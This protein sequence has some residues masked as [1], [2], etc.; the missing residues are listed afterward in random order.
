MKDRVGES[1]LKVILTVGLC[2]LICNMVP[3]G[4]PLTLLLTDGRF[5]LGCL[6]CLLCPSPALNAPGECALTLCLAASILEVFLWLPLVILHSQPVV[7][8]GRG[9]E[10]PLGQ[11]R[12]GPTETRGWLFFGA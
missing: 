7:H 3:R 5:R 8:L 6:L 11:G 10:P 12:D 2:L 9:L 4:G 1:S